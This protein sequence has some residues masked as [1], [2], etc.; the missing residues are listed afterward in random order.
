[1]GRKKKVGAPEHHLLPG[2]QD[3]VITIEADLYYDDDEFIVPLETDL[4]DIRMPKKE[5]RSQYDDDDDYNFFEARLE[6]EYFTTITLPR[7][8][9]TICQTHEEVD[10]F[11]QE[12][13]AAMSEFGDDE[14]VFMGADTEKD[15]ATLQ[16]SL[17]FVHGEG[18]IFEKHVLF[19]LMSKNEGQG[20]ILEG[21][22]PSSLVSF[23]LDS[24]LVWMRKVS[25]TS[26]QSYRA[27]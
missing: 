14:H 2:Y 20:A 21:G 6:E 10:L 19:Q 12:A 25:V 24:R 18:Q 27:H 4:K 23:L 5:E 16:I 22:V 7:N 3:R 9:R 15:G 13:K 17:Q 26:F 11:C 8:K 1:M